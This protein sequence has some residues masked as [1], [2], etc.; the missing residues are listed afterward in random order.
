[1]YCAANRLNRLGTLTYRG[2]GNF[3]PA[4]LR[5]DMADFFRR[6]RPSVGEPLP[7]L[8]VPEWHPGGHG[9]HAH[10][11]V[12]RWIPRGVIERSWRRGFVDIRLLGDLPV[13][14]G[15][16]GEARLAARYLAKYVG[17]DLEHGGQP[18]GRHRYEVAEGYQPRAVRIEAA[19]S[20]EVLD[21]AE[22]YM[23]ATPQLVWR[24]R[25]DAEWARPPALWASWA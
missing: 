2:D 22:T 16:L 24:S 3:D 21:W 1:L 8:W 9:L 18:P 14:S 13:G 15:S 11:A 20:D 10:F 4:G 12:A 6:L 17:K 19:T 7:Y 25:D 5:V 23:G